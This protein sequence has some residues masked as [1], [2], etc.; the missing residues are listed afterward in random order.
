[1]P[2]SPEKHIAILGGGITGLAAAYRLT[3]LGHRVRVFEQGPRL[4]GAIRTEISP[5]GW[6]AEAGPNSFQD[7]LPELGPLLRELGLESERIEASAAA[8]NRYVARR[9]RLVPVPMSPPALLS[10]SLFSPWARLRVVTELLRRPRTRTTDLS[11]AAFGR[12]HFGQDVL[13]YGLQPMASGVF[14]GDAEKLSTRY[15]FPRFW[16]MERTHGSLLRGQMAAAKTRRAR[17]ESPAPKLISFRRG[18]QT[19][20]DALAARLPP[21]SVALNCDV[22]GLVPGERWQVI[23]NDRRSVQT[24]PFD[25]II[26]ALPAGSLA[27]LAIG[28]LAEK[29][30]ISLDS[31]PHPPVASFFLGFRR[32]QVGHPLDGFGALIPAVEKR[33]SLGILFSST[34]FP[35]RAPVDHVAITVLAGGA[36]HPEVILQPPEKLWEIIRPDLA[37]L[38]QVTGEPVFWRH[39]LW[40]RAIPQYNLGHERHFET[41]AAC[42]RKHPGLFIGGQVRD[43]IALPQCLQAGLK[44]ADRV[45][46]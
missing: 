14:A 27:K 8:K 16:E 28:P 24:K 10:S 38:L 29:P 41:I 13:N 39:T 21:G 37:D 31:I 30:L 22:E 9:G 36:L 25:G 17:G 4:G 44:L 46:A 32:D 11:F 23:W 7:S 5:D 26:A 34:L 19:L 35:E 45:L 33:S 15:A 18:L 1:L 12:A 43:G 2:A 40:P 6:L 3:M 42:E 20:T